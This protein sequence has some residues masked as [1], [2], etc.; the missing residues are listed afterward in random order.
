[1]CRAEAMGMVQWWTLLWISWYC[2]TLSAEVL[3]QYKYFVPGQRQHVSLQA[4]AEP[5]G[6]EFIWEWTS[7]DGSYKIVII[8]IQSN[9]DFVWNSKFFYFKGKQVWHSSGTTVTERRG[10]YFYSN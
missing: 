9:G 1:M 4:P 5:K 2:H 6:T 7:H 3:V 10:F 8:T